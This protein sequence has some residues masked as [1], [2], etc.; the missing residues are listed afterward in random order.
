MTNTTTTDQL[1]FTAPFQVEVR[2]VPLAPPAADELQVRTLCSAVSPGTE[3]LLYRNQLPDSMALDSTLDAL[4]GTSQYPVQYGYACVGDVQQVG[5]DVDP[6]WLGRTVFSFQP[7][8]RHFNARPD[9][10]IAVPDGISAEAAAF[11]PNMET[12]VN[13]VQ[14]G[15]PMLGERVVVLGQG[16]VGLL[17]SG[18]LAQYP[19][20]SLQAIEGQSKRQEL[21]LQLGVQAVFSPADAS[22]NPQPDLADADLIYEISGHPEA[23]NLAVGLSGYASRIVIGSWYGNKPVSVDL[24]GEAHRNRLQLITSQ[25]STLAPALSGRWSKQRRFDVAWEMIRRLDPT[26]LITHRLPLREAGTLY[27]QLHDARTGSQDA[28][29]Q[30]LFV[31]SAD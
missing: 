11:L 21:A 3:L 26:Q 1:W 28:M 14:D 23:L 15:Q 5:A 29:V 9:Q 30:P 25:V 13:L 18:V 17:L 31:Y 20:A 6:A 4:Q 16:V 24:G 22:A 8:A 19:L 2:S 12:A 10:L 7:H 27:Q